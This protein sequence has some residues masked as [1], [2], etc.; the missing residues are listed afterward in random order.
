MTNS[1]VKQLLQILVLTASAA[2]ALGAQ[3]QPKDTLVIGMTQFPSTFHPN[4]DVMTAKYYVLHMTMRPFTAYDYNWN[5]VCML[6]TELPTMENGRAV[7]EEYGDGKQ[8]IAVT[9]TIQPDATWGDGTPVSTKDVEFT[10]EVGKNPDSG[11]VG[12][13]FYRRV[14]SLEIVDDKTFTLH[15]DRVEFKYNELGLYLLP[16]HIER[17]IYEASTAF[18][19]RNR[20]AYD[21]D[22]FNPALY[23]GPYRISGV[24]AGAYVELERN[25]SWWGKKPFYD[26]IVVRI[27]ENTA[28]LEANLL[29]K[30]IDFIAGTLGV[31]L[32]Q[33]LSIK[34]RHSDDF[35]FNFRP[36]LIYEHID[37]NQD[38]PILSDVRVRQ[39]LMYATNRTA[40]SEKIFEGQQPVADGFI[41]PLDSV[42]N[43]NLRKYPYDPEKARKLLEQAGWLVN[44]STGIRE[45]SNGE[46]LKLEFSTTSGSRVR[47]LVQQ[48]IQSNWHQLGISVEIKN[49]PPRVY[50]GDTVEKRKFPHLAM[51]AWLS[52]PESPP[53]STLHSTEIPTPENNFSGTNYPGFRNAEMDQLI[54]D[55]EVELDPGERLPMWARM[56]EIYSEQLPALPLY[57]RVE[58]FVIPK[59]LKGVTP[60]GNSSTT[61]LWIENWYT[62]LQGD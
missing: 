27:I 53:R 33:A 55:V 24:T 26:K 23:Y 28:A 40:I 20:T 16:A 14:R 17:P 6:C 43:P 48:A 12:S 10:I 39:A 41:S 18:E 7:V 58:P 31:T 8:G 4:Y 36:G 9:F 56:Q 5:L 38:S 11:V 47:E 22:A 62:Q 54:D 45:N 35:D 51:Y 30:S 21:T 25:D 57:F 1:K 60:T 3:A 59:W 44:E 37:V 19:Y 49:Q 50:F 42:F 52:V 15:M 13:E 34:K 29:S 46:P 2:F 61:T 32:D